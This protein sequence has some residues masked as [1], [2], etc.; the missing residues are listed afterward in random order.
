MNGDYFGYIA[1]AYGISGFVLAAL[2][3]YTFLDARSAARRLAALEGKR[4]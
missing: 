1:A 4:R 2:S 3:L